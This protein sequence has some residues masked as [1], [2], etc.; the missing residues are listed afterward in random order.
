MHERRTTGPHQR[1]PRPQD[2]R[3]KGDH[4][5]RGC[6]LYISMTEYLTVDQTLD[7]MMMHLGFE[8]RG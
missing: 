6:L 3:K 1:G 7:Q 2:C 5:A 4:D 8:D